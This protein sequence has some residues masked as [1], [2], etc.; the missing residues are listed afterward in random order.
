MTHKGTLPLETERLILRRFTEDDTEAMFKNWASDPEVSKFLTWQPHKDTTVSEN[1]LRQWVS[2]YDNLFNYNWAIVPKTLNEPIGSISVVRSNM[3]T[4]TATIG[5]CI[6]KAWWHKGL[7]TEAFTAVIKFLFEEIGVNRI[8]ACH[9]PRNPNSGA[10]MRKCGL[11][12]EGTNRQAG[13]NNMD[14][15]CDEVWY[16][17]IAEDYFIKFK[18]NN[19]H[20]IIIHGAPGCG[21]T[22]IAKK[23]H[24]LYKCPWFEFGW[25]PEFNNLNPHTEMSLKDEEQM[26]FETMYL[27]VNNYRAHGFEKVILTDLNDKRVP[28]MLQK[29]GVTDTVIITLFTRN[30]DLIRERVLNRENGNEYRDW[31]QSQKIN[32]MIQNR[33]VLSNEYRI[34][35][36]GMDIEEM[37]AQA[38]TLLEMHKPTAGSASYKAIDYFSYTE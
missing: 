31:E 37:A 5:Y 23:L 18:S 22:T 8:Q 3:E 25:I 27:V 14:G 26:T 33:P 24:E 32:C 17:I 36:D 21:K 1:I 10:V 30:D 29:F 19:P 4:E 38:A 12:Y 7:M 13:K 16:A 34:C 28:E 6:G 35:T 2:D 20:L 9:D 11:V 15:F